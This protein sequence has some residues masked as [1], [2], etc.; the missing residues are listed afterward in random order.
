[1]KTT[2]KPANLTLIADGTY[3]DREGSAW[4]CNPQTGWIRVG[5]SR[6]SRAARMIRTETQLRKTSCESAFILKRP[7]KRVMTWRESVS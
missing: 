4:I 6:A 7:T 2:S 3:E 1:M 5:D